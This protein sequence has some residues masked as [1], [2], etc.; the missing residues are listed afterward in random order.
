MYSRVAYISIL[1]VLLNSVPLIKSFNLNL[2]SSLTNTLL[3]SDEEASP[4]FLSDKVATSFLTQPVINN[5]IHTEI[6]KIRLI[7]FPPKYFLI[8]MFFDILDERK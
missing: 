8:V 3:L 6:A 2:S 7:V 5:S 4:F 1:S